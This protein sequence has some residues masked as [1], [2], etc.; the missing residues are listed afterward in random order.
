M[1]DRASLALVKAKSEMH[2]NTSGIMDILISNEI[3]GGTANQTMASF[4]RSES[5]LDSYN[6]RDSAS[7]RAA[8]SAVAA[9]TANS[10]AAD[11]EKISESFLN[12]LNDAALSVK[13]RR[14]SASSSMSSQSVSMVAT[15]SVTAHRLSHDHRARNTSKSGK[16]KK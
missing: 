3:N 16:K 14:M 1:V 4:V 11:Y 10:I 7:M 8:A 9:E 6:E 12:S 2:L 15:S 13:P 5:S